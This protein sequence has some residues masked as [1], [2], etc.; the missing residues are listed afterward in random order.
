MERVPF[1]IVALLFS[2]LVCGDASVAQ[3]SGGQFG[4]LEAVGAE[5][6]A[7]VNKQWHSVDAECLLQ[8]R[9]V[10][11]QGDVR[12]PNL[13][14]IAF[15]VEGRG[16]PTAPGANALTRSQ[17]LSVKIWAALGL[18]AI[19]YSIYPRVQA[20]E[21]DAKPRNT[22]WDMCKFWCMLCVIYV[23]L[24]MYSGPCDGLA[25]DGLPWYSSI[26]RS[27]Q[28]SSGPWGL[29]A[30]STDYPLWNGDRT[31]NYITF[32][33]FVDRC[34]IPGFSMIS[35]IFTARTYVMS[36]FPSQTFAAKRSS[37]RASLRDLVLNNATLV[38]LYILLSGML[39][40]LSTLSPPAFSH[41]IWK[42]MMSWFTMVP[43]L[44][45]EPAAT[46]ANFVIPPELPTHWFLGSL[47]LW[48]MLVPVMA[49]LRWPVLFL[50]MC[51]SLC[52]TGVAPYFAN[53]TLSF[54]PFFVLGF[55]L[56]GGGLRAEERDARMKMTES[57]LVDWRARVLAV[58]VLL[59]YLGLAHM[60]ELPET[61]AMIFCRPVAF[62]QDIPTPWHL[63]GLFTDLL[64]MA[65]TALMNLAFFVFVFAAPPSPMLAAA[66]SRTLYAY[67]LHDRMGLIYRGQDLPMALQKLVG[68]YGMSWNVAAELAYGVC[69]TLFSGSKLV[70]DL[71]HH[72]VQPQ[73]LVDLVC[74]PEERVKNA[75]TLPESSPDLSSR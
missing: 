33:T 26:C 22:R 5:G 19:C 57:W 75:E 30:N 21:A 58:A 69:I 31:V 25:D 52:R 43:F 17:V 27:V 66:G 9:V 61:L 35:G 28:K 54:L 67:V 18:F 53:G 56:A 7:A 11:S 37:L 4:E 41:N 49:E 60:G 36:E 40:A 46:K 42:D 51:A 15:N 20:P 47:F 38:P 63:G 24:F 8:T 50:A 29:A 65:F 3:R 32:N 1:Y 39:A 23:H 48:R 72:F 2:R 13:D 64:R 73:W 71:T 44:P 74:P 70:E 6:E 45:F 14:R 34:G 12:Q 62:F 10:E 16:L 68:P 55:A 59:C